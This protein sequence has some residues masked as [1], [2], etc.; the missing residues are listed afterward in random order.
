MKTLFLVRHAKSSWDDA[1]VADRERPLAGRGERDAPAMGK[2]LERRGVRPDLIVSSPALRARL[3]AELLAEQLEYKRKDIVI[4]DRLYARGPDALLEVIH[5]V[6][7]GIKRVMLVGHNPE[8]TELAHR[9]CRDIA[10]LPTCAVA[11]F[12]F[13]ARS[14]ADIGEASLA[15]TE[16]DY[17][18]KA[19]GEAPRRDPA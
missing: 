8:L 13:D 1:S 15:G 19:S 6:D 9:I 18:K 7:D 14:W 11:R 10:H 16:L 4:D 5:A 3:T 17:P 2:R 12:T